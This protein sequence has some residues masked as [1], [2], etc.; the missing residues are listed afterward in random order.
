M[1]W[2]APLRGPARER[3]EDRC[4]DGDL[5]REGNAPIS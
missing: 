2:C 3:Y 1:S 4:D 5:V